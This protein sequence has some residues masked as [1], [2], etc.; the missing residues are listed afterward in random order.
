MIVMGSQIE[1]F[2][3]L[4]IANAEIIIIGLAKLGRGCTSSID[5]PGSFSIPVHQLPGVFAGIAT[6]G[7]NGN[8]LSKPL[9]V[10]IFCN[11]K[12]RRLNIKTNNCFGSWITSVG[13][14][15]VDIENTLE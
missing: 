5:G 3:K 13:Y 9:S 6:L 11:D 2:G 7:L 10:L 4:F 1:R 8:K 15:Q 12:E 14:D